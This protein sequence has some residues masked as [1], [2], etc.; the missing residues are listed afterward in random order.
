[1]KCHYRIVSVQFISPR[2]QAVIDGKLAARHRKP[3]F[4]DLGEEAAVLAQLSI[5][6]LCSQ[7]RLR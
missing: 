6:V 5:R 7:F 3:A 2:D 4:H 1:L